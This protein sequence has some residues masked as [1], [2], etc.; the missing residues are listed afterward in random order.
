MPELHMGVKFPVTWGLE[1]P[2]PNPGSKRTPKACPTC[3]L[4]IRPTCHT[5]PN[6]RSYP[7]SLYLDA[8]KEG[9]IH[10]LVGS[11]VQKPDSVFFSDWSKKILTCMVCCLLISCHTSTR[12]LARSW[13]E[14]GMVQTKRV[15]AKKSFL[16]HSVS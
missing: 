2:T 6:L 1:L 15:F 16:L 3:N 11:Y 4:A 9:M 8:G 12:L 10:L 7:P 5:Q 14:N 13:S